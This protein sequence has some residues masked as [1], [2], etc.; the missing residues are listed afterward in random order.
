[1][2]KY[3]LFFVLSQFSLLLIGQNNAPLSHSYYSYLEK[4]MH[5]IGVPKHTSLKPFLY[6]TYDTIFYNSFEP[7]VSNKSLIHNF[8]NSSLFSIEHKDYNFVINNLVIQSI[9]FL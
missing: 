9:N 2:K 3:V 8:L 1:M 6:S 5:D 4:D 7:I